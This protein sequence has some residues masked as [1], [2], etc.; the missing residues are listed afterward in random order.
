MK[1]VFISQA[2][3]LIEYYFERYGIT[4]KDINQPLLLV[5]RMGR[6]RSN[7]GPTYLI[8]ELCYLTG[9][10]GNFDEQRR[11]KILE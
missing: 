5:E 10:P 3:S 9:I 11:K 2:F 4:I 7:S 6:T 1:S 8:P